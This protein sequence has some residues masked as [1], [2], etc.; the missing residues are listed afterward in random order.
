M[1]ENASQWRV[2][3]KGFFFHVLRNGHVGHEKK[4]GEGGGGGK[5][6]TSGLRR[7]K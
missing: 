3:S 7:E 4:L 1:K 5:H 2:E 6:V